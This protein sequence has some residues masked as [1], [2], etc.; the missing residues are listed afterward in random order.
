ML[1]KEFSVAIMVSDAKKSAAWYSEKLGFET[2]NEDHWVTAWPKGAKWKLHL[3]EGKLEPGNTGIG[4]YS[5][6]LKSTVADL[7]KK[8]VKFAM[9]YT[10]SEWGEMAQL[11][12]PDGNVIWISAGGP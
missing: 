9:D 4:L 5:D 12:D 2:S 6:D 8:G 7:K 3:C 1:S 11:K 10:K